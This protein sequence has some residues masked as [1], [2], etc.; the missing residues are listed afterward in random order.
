[1]GESAPEASSA[2]RK[3]NKPLSFILI[4][5]FP[6]ILHFRSVECHHRCFRFHHD[7]RRLRDIRERT[8][9]A[10]RSCKAQEG[11]CSTSPAFA[12][13]LHACMHACALHGFC[14][15]AYILALR[16]CVWAAVQEKEGEGIL[17]SRLSAEAPRGRCA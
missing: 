13:P 9:E 15:H 14:M 7:H 6:F 1:M 8:A 11:D 3:Y 17:V 5:V 12:F 16:T 4:K 10:A 2:L